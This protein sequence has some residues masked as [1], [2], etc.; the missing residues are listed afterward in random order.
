LQLALFNIFVDNLDEGIA[1]ALRN[2]ADDTQLGG[3]VNLLDDNKAL[4][5]DLDR[6]DQWVEVNCMS[7]NKMKCRVLHFGHNNP[8]Q[9]YRP[10]ADWPESCTEIRV[11]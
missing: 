1:C 11:C 5:R 9:C 7:F 3:S 2:S 4:R 10:G 8:T 6:L